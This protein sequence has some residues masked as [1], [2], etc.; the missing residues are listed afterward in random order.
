MSVGIVIADDQAMIRT[1]LRLVIGTQPD[2]T[3]VGEASDGTEAAE[4]AR[5]LRPDV[6][7]LDIAMPRVDGLTAAGRILAQPDPPGVIMLTTYDTDEN[8][9]RALRAGSAASCSRSRRPS[10]CSPPSAAPPGARPCSIRP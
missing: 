2:L 5:T 7:L 4:L 9:D 10:I 8:L 1:G 6:V 3:V